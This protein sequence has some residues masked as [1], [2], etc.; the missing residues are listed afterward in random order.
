VTQIIRDTSE[1]D[2]PRAAS[3][4]QLVIRA[5]TALIIESTKQLRVPTVTAVPSMRRFTVYE[6]AA[7]VYH[8][9]GP[10]TMVWSIQITQLP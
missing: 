10:G 6:N 1:S 5:F 2:G 3:A 4:S 9:T 8:A 7:A